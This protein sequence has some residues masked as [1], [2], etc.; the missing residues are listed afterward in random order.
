VD[1]CELGGRRIREKE[2][3]EKEKKDLEYVVL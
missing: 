1:G 2:K 3:V